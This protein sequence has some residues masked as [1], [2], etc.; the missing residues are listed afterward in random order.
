[1]YLCSTIH[2][3]ML[4]K[5]VIALDS[6]KGCMTSLEAGK[7]IAR[8][9]CKEFPGCEV[10]VMP[11][12]DGGEGLLDAL[13]DITGGQILKIQVHGPLMETR[14]ACYGLSA[15]GSTAFVEMAQ[16]SGLPLV[17]K[18]SRNPLLTTSYGTGELIADA[19][20]RGCR[21]LFVGL[22]GSA[23]NDAGIGLAACDVHNPLYGPEGAAHV[24]APQK[25]ATP[26]MVRL[27]D[28]GLRHFA[29]VV[30]AH[31]GLDISTLQGAGA[32][33][34]IGG[35]LSAFLHADLKPGI[36]LVLES[37]DF[38]ALIDGA[39]LIIT[40]EGR[41]DLQTLM[42]KV[43]AGILTMARRQGIP[44]ILLAGQV[45]DVPKLLQA[46]F[47]DVRCINPLDIPLP[48]AIRPDFA[49]RQVRQAA[50][51]AIRDF[52]KGHG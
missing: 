38:P 7:S 4:H 2:T 23:T 40:G 12:A 48:I 17:P 11:V 26:E 47:Q 36:E 30:H 51:E 37:G 46:G 45:K 16:A 32:A 43:P 21:Q 34:G 15:D 18:E 42:G 14:Q 35:S 3:I 13:V 50:L 33:G 25:G 49:I 10:K 19:L 29:D 20:R 8:G 41:A 31:T 22:G 9:I 28:E 6:F 1:M 44:V 52:L 27:L 24:F 39:D 5:I